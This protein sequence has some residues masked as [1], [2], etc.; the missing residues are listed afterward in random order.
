M[1]YWNKLFK[2]KNSGNENSVQKEC[3][4]CGHINPDYVKFCAGCGSELKDML[5]HFDAFISYRRET[6]S[7]LA[8]LLKV[9]L[10]NIFHKR[11]FLDIKELQVGKFDE[12]LLSRIEETTNF[13]LILSKASMERCVDKSDWL[14]REI[15]HALLT[16]RNII[17]VFTEGFEFPKPEVW[18]LLLDKMKELRSFQAVLYSHLNQDSAI[19][20]IASYMK[21]LVSQHHASFGKE[22]EEAIQKKL[23]DR[24]GKLDSGNPTLTYSESKEINIIEYLESKSYELNTL[25]EKHNREEKELTLKFEVDSARFIKEKILLLNKQNVEL[26]NEFLDM[27]FIFSDFTPKNI[28]E[29]FAICDFFLDISLYDYTKL[30]HKIWLRSNIS[31]YDLLSREISLLQEKISKASIFT[32]T[33]LR[34]D[35]ANYFNSQCTLPNR[36]SSVLDDESDSN[37]KGSF[38]AD[39]FIEHQKKG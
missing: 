9:Q 25:K 28:V 12:A 39:F 24:S 34:N 13:I 1:N 15:M 17:P 3:G 27:H 35:H 30:S 19:R 10:E 6:G 32:W 11:I 14:K 8:S 23:N 20:Q 29:V 7:D 18:A 38:P 36:V 26:R 33:V 21:T 22:N 5:E 2:F 31:C 37:S 4:T 16:K